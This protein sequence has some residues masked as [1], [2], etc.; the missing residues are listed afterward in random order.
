MRV[1]F[2]GSKALGASI[3]N[4]LYKISSESLIG[5]ITFDDSNDSR[6]ALNQ[7]YDFAKRT[8]K[9]LHVLN[10]ASGLASAIE[11]LNPDI[12]IV[13]GWYW[14][15]KRELLESVPYGWLGIHASLL[16]KYRGGSPLVWAMINGETETGISLFYFD[17][18]MDTG[19]IVA[20]RRIKIG[21]DYTI[22]DLLSQ[23][24]QQSL[25]VIQEMYPRLLSGTAPSSKQ[26][27]TQATYTSLRN[28]SDGRIDWSNNAT[29]I[30]NFVRSQTH[31]YPGAFFYCDGTLIR[32]WSAQLFEYPYF[33]APGQVVM[34]ADDSVV[35]TCG[36]GTGLSLLKVQADGGEEQK[37]SQLL[38]FGQR[39]S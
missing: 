29:R 31:P 17:E 26:D 32:L 28:P 38:K 6:S 25:E 13:V 35:V 23:V 22:A 37:A 18:G 34:V 19:N 2:L 7:F 36:D 16:P 39:L 3:L 9:L 15:L 20:Q 10:K 30:Y 5:A 12:C 24:E 4:E 8:G 14:V 1:V 27:H 11:K 33:G 21:F